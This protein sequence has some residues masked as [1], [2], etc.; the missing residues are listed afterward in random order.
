MNVAAEEVRPGR[1]RRG[2]RVHLDRG[3]RDELADVDGLAEA[4][5]RVERDVVQHARVPVV[6]RDVELRPG[7]RGQRVE[8][9][10]NVLRDDGDGNG[11]RADRTTAGS[12]IRPAVG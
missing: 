5:V 7:V 4:A 12:A 9:E 11:P 2:E 1:R 3:T 6:Q 10:Q 8:V